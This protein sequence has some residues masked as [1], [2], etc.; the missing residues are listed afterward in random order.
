M[1][2]PPFICFR[3]FGIS[4][5]PSL[6]LFVGYRFIDLS[7]CGSAGR[8]RRVG[9]RSSAALLGWTWDENMYLD[10]AEGSRVTRAGANEHQKRRMDFVG[11]CCGE[12]YCLSFKPSP[13]FIYP[14]PLIHALMIP[15]SLL[16][17]TIPIRHVYL[18][19]ALL[20][21]SFSSPTACLYFT[22]NP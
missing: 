15:P 18:P 4:F 12:T 21:P 22:Y 19:A 14:P 3:R 7:C 1:S 17:R 8:F 10:A 13:S 2:Y 16:C 6:P 20:H 11:L 5:P 9:G